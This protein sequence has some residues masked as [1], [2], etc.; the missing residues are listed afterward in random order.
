MDRDRA[1]VIAAN[2]LDDADNVLESIDET[3]SPDECA[4]IT[5]L[6]TVASGLYLGVIAD[7]LAS[8]ADR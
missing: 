1:M 8:Q 5:A 2:M 3:P 7:V 4:R 6:A